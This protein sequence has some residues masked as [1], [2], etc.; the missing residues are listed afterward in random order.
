MRIELTYNGFADRD[1]YHS[2]ISP[3]VARSGVEPLFTPYQSVALTV[4]LPSQTIA[5][6][7]GLEPRI[8]V[9]KTEVL[10]LHHR[11]MC[12]APKQGFEPRLTESESVVLPLDDLGKFYVPH[13]R[14][15][16]PTNW[17]VANY[18]IH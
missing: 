18:S 15:E 2:V 10:P 9:P 6:R 4:V 3:Y 1:Y 13:E 17:F 11:N 7:P 5:F 16:L 14:F 8:S 12:Y